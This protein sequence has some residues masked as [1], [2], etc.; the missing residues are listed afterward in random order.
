MMEDQFGEA[1]ED[2]ETCDGDVDTTYLEEMK[3]AWWKISLARLER[4]MKHVMVM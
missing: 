2:N 1:G 3:W 4:T